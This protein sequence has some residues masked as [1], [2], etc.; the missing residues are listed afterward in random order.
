MQVT[1]V[2]DTPFTNKVREQNPDVEIRGDETFGELTE[3]LGK[4]KR[5]RPRFTIP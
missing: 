5:P 2:T 1:V 3:K 4:I